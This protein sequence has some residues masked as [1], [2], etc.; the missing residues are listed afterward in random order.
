MQNIIKILK[1]LQKI[2]STKI[3]M[4]GSYTRNFFIRTC[5]D[6]AEKLDNNV[7]AVMFGA[8]IYEFMK[9]TPKNQK[10]ISQISIQYDNENIASITLQ[11]PEKRFIRILFSRRKIK[12]DGIIIMDKNATLIQDVKC[13]DF[14]M[15][16]L[17]LPVNYESQ[18]DLIDLCKGIN[19]IKMKRV[20]SIASPRVCL[21]T[22]HPNLIKA[23]SMAAVSNFD[24]EE[25]LLREISRYAK[26]MKEVDP[27]IVRAE[28]NKIL[29]CKTPSKYL[30]LLEKTGLLR[31]FCSELSSCVGVTQEPKYHKYDVF[32]HCLYSC[33][34]VEPDLVI[35]LAAVLHDIGKPET[36]KIRNGKITFF[37]HEV[38]SKRKAEAFLNRLHYDTNTKNRVLNLVALH[39]YHYTDN[40]S[41]SGIRKFIRKAGVTVDDIKTI[42][43]LP[44]FKLRAG[45]RLGSGVKRKPITLN[46]KQFEKRIRKILLQSV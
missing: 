31:E 3:F 34:N 9:H 23:I 20:S 11:T 44:L 45:E 15:N 6:P 38:I 27:D 25:T 5:G 14:K 17:Y 36:R 39:M 1:K 18:K 7:E 29:T 2:T 16:S 4:V 43:Q 19:D 46:Q 21:K 37:K 10:L 13:R 32:N 33:D 30:S 12:P 35:R 26:L 28:F 42:N 41:D 40:Y 22:S 8:S 24:V